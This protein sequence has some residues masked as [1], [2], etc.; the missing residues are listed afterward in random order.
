M[1]DSR[2]EV[3]DIEIRVLLEAVHEVCGQDFRNYAPASLKRRIL[4]CM[5]SEGLATVSAL[6]D[7]ALHDPACLRRLLSSLTINVSSVFRDPAFFQALRRL[8]IPLL[9][10]AGSFRVWHAGCSTGEEVYSLAMVLEEEG[11]LE[12]GVVYATDLNE[13]NLARA[14]EG[15]YPLA[16]VRERGRAQQQAGGR[17]PLASYYDACGDL[18]VLS[19]RLRRSVVWGQHSLATDASFNDFHLILCRN[20]MIYFNAAL[21]GRVHRLLHES[22][23]MGGALALGRGET[24]R[25]SPLADCYETLDA[26]EKI[27]RKVK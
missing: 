12:R 20:V 27:F 1:A 22:L 6:Q 21:Q 9:R 8:V 25:F 11:L 24:I 5:G 7:R 17:H 23:V 13:D 15:I 18:A 16:A 19:P 14:R 2:P 4:V 3:Q 26:D 10:Q